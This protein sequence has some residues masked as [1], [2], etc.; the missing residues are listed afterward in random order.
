VAKKKIYELSELDIEILQAGM[1]N[2]YLITQHFF[3]QPGN[4]GW[5]L[6][7]NFDPE[8]AWQV[9]VHRA[10][11][12]RIIII[13]GFGSGKT[14]GIAASACIW[15][16]TTRNF[17]F[18][19]CAPA[20]WQSELMYQFVT[21]DLAIGT[22]FGNMIY[23]KPRRPYPVV[24]IRYR[25]HGEVVR[26]KF[27]F[28]SVDKNATAILSWEGDW[29]NIDEAG[30]IDDLKGTVRNLGTRLRGHASGRTR[31]GRMSL[32]TNS[33]DNDYLW[34]L[35]D[36]A[37]SKPEKYLSMTVS[38]RHNG[39]ITEE[40]L[41]MMLLDVPEE[42]HDRFI[43]GARPVGKGHY[44]AQNKVFAC[45][46]EE[47]S[48]FLIGAVNSGVPG[49][50]MAKLHGSGIVHFETPYHN[51]HIY[52]LLGDPGTDNAPN[53][54]SPVCQVWDVSDFPKYKASLA[55]LWWGAG[56]DS[57]TPFIAKFLELM[58]KYNPILSAVDNTGPQKNTAEL[59]N[60][61][62]QSSRVDPTKTFDWLGTTVDI[63]HVLNPIIGGFDFSG[64][65]K[66]TYLIA[67]RMMIEARLFAWPSFVSGMRSQLTNYDPAKDVAGK[68]K[69][70]QDLVATYCM[71]A[72]AVQV[73]FHIDPETMAQGAEKENPQ[74]LEQVLGRE[75]RPVVRDLVYARPGSGTGQQITEQRLP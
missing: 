19:N 22:I 39:N 60:T 18:M 14:K 37:R 20:A 10:S 1:E 13:G 59:L 43:D 56:N 15:G 71:S 53:R 34:Y 6:D 32:T 33:W 47:Y 26:S 45:E 9:P 25:I 73:W 74:I 4:N 66:P 64:A 48:D 61:Y 68:P 49:F 28:M 41:E 58:A 8:G 54:N 63:S 17:K 72:Y 31:L 67:G 57:I 65:K 35:Y 38:S 46:D 70:S 52:M 24:E 75:T 62:I 51:D 30:L 16:M 12:K 36:L 42:E 29:V 2:P 27:E 3:S 50:E 55:A 69:I 5:N 11:Q 44:F 23:A 21:E 7:E 40:Q